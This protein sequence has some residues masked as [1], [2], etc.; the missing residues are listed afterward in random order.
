[1]T[2]TTRTTRAGRKAGFTLVE[3]LIA[4]TLLALL[5]TSIGA[6]M[7]ASMLSYSENDK[8]A[9]YD[10]T[11]RLLQMRLR[12][13]IRTAAAVDHT[14]DYN[15]LIIYPPPNDDGV[16]KIEYEFDGSSRKLYYRRVT[17]TDSV[18]QVVLSDSTAVKPN[19]L[20]CSYDT[21]QDGEGIW[22]TRRAFV[23][24]GLETDGR[25]KTIVCSAAPRRNS[26]Y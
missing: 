11:V 25:Y 18:T 9:T 21:V 19:Y 10:Q 12:Q 4:V 5:L 7:H 2:H 22:C 20:Y 3:M 17:E 26:L 24:L 15:R 6:A 14:A 13:E 16:V 1:M 8:A 23:T